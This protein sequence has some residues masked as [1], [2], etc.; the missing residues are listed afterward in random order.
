MRSSYKRRSQDF[1]RRIVKRYQLIAYKE[2]IAEEQRWLDMIKPEEFGIKYYNYQ[3]KAKGWSWHQNEHTRKIV[4]EKIS[5]SWNE[6]IA[7]GWKVSEER[8]KKNSIITTKQWKD[9]IHETNR[10]K[11]DQR[12][13]AQKESTRLHSH[14]MKGKT[15][16]N[17]GKKY[18]YKSRPK[19]KGRVCP[20]KGWTKETHPQLSNSGVKKGNIPWNKNKQMEKV[21]CIHCKKEGSVNNMK[22]WHFDNCRRNL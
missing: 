3:P 18:P 19:A 13:D 9:G 16:P 15:S 8:R 20:I 17:K 2:L 6:K 12:T 14:G 21:M 5:N 4:R 1:K 11:G 7:S 22:R 10:L